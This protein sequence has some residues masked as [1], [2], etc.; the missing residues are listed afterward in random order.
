MT[1]GNK[2]C[3]WV[4]VGGEKID[5]PWDVYTLMANLTM[6]KLLLNLVVSTYNAFFFTIEVKKLSQHT[7]V[8]EVIHENEVLPDS[9]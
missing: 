1:F 4:T 8:R 5:Y 6:V 3:T 2:N 9:R 7:N